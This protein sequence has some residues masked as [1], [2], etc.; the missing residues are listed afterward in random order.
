M[1]GGIRFAQWR[2]VGA[3]GEHHMPYQPGADG[4]LDLVFVFHHDGQIATRAL[5]VAHAQAETTTLNEQVGVR[6]KAEK[7]KATMRLCSVECRLNGL[8]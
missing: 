3:S 8:K 7:T 4:D 5:D 2:G 1:H 6:E